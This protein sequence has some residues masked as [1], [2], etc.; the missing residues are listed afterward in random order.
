[1]RGRN[2][3]DSIVLISEA[4]NL[5][6]D[7]VKLLIG[8]IGNGSRIFFDGSLKQ[9]DSTIFKN[10][11]GLKLLLNISKSEEFSKFFSVVRLEQIE[12]S[13]TAQIADYLDVISS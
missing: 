7:Q 13:K 1:M 5:D 3:E 2:F 9:I 4:Q 10:K 8:R 6:E 11:N 12:R